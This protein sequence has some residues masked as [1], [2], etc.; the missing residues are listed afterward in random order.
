MG[1][2]V[3]DLIKIF[4]KQGLYGNLQVEN[5]TIQKLN[6]YDCE[7]T[8]VKGKMYL[9]EKL[10]NDMMDKLDNLERRL[11]ELESPNLLAR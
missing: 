10:M 1:I 2:Q 11:E 5:P 7:L 9:L 6:S 8:Y 3:T 4:I